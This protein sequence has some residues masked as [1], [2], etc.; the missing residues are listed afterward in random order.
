[1]HYVGLQQRRKQ[2][3]MPTMM[4][5][6]NSPIHYHPMLK[7][8]ANGH[9]VAVPANIGIDPTKD[10]MQMAGLHTHDTSG[11]I[12]VEGARRA[13]LDKLFKI[14]GVPLSSQQLGP[15]HA[16]GRKAL[17]MW[18]NGKPSRAFGALKLADRQ[19]ITISFGT[20]SRPPNG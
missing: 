7:V 20:D 2:A 8:F 13:T 10:P 14:W 16:A 18:V 12:H 1:Q 4:D 3:G 19:R 17:R 11:T 6:M 5:T 15:Y 9:Q